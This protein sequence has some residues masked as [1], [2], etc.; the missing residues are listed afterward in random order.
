MNTLYSGCGTMSSILDVEYLSTLAGSGVTSTTNFAGWLDKQRLRHRW[1]QAEMARQIG[2][3]PGRVSEWL[4]GK[5]LPSK[6]NVERIAD[7]LGYP[8][9]DV[10][11]YAGLI[12]DE[13][14]LDPLSDKVELLG[15]LQR[16]SL[17]DETRV[18]VLRS[19]LDGMIEDDVR[20]RR[21]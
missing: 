14:E 16:V 15:K 18:M 12:P 10:A 3:S 9:R 20:R 5:R 6:K 17:A 19:L 13:E 21:G 11:V 1:T 8:A 7:I 4:S 2:T